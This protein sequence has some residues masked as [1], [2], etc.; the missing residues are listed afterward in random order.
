MV[1]R[2]TIAN[3]FHL[4]VGD[5]VCMNC[6]NYEEGY[7]SLYEDDRNEIDLCSHFWPRGKK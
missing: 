7:C 4:K 6:D 5:T 1:S 2:E 3:A